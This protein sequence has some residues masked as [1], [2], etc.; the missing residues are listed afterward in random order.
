MEDVQKTDD[1]PDIYAIVSKT[2]NGSESLVYVVYTLSLAD[3]SKSHA[4]RIRTAQKSSYD[5]LLKSARH[6]YVSPIH[7]FHSIHTKV[8]TRFRIVKLASY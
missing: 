7:K 2:N 1:Y 6:G 3:R 4:I 5:E 8:G